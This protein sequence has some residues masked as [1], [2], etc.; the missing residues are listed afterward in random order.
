VQRVT[1]SHHAVDSRRPPLHLC[2]LHTV[3]EEDNSA[4]ASATVAALED[5]YTDADLFETIRHIRGDEVDGAGTHEVVHHIIGEATPDEQALHASQAETAPYFGSLA[6]SGMETTRRLTEAEHLW[7]AFVL[8]HLVPRCCVLI[9][10]TSLSR[11]GFAKLQSFT[12]LKRMPRASI[13]R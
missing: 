10:I 6:R 3:S 9:E 11:V 1:P 5:A 8:P 4:S 2:A 7:R 13:S 12:S